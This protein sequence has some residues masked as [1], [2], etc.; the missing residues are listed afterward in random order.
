MKY[1]QDMAEFV[2]Y[3]VYHEVD[4]RRNPNKVANI[5]NKSMSKIWLQVKIM[6][7]M[8][9]NLNKVVNI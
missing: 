4:V 7:Q 3:T 6:R 8:I 5:Q 1:E 9:R 2:L